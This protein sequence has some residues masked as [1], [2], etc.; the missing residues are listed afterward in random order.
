[1]MRLLVDAGADANKQSEA[2]FTAL[3]DAAQHGVEHAAGMM[4]LLLDAG[5]DANKHE[6][7]SYT[8]LTLPTIYSV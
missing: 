4:R 7:V 5:A 8:H 3:M 1:M 2:G 6:P